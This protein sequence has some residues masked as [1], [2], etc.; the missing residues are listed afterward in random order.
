MRV[1]PD[2]LRRIAASRGANVDW[3]AYRELY[4]ARVALQG[5]ESHHRKATEVLHLFTRYVVDRPEPNSKLVRSLE[6]IDNSVYTRYLARRKKDPGKAKGTL[7]SVA[8]LNGDIRYLNAAFAIALRPTN[9]FPDRLGVADP[10]WDAPHMRLLKEP[11]TRPRSLTESHLGRLFSACQQAARPSIPGVTPEVWWQTLFLVAYTTG[12]RC[13]ALL[14]MPRPSEDDL[15]SETIRLPAEFD[16]SQEER[17]FHCHPQVAEMVRQI[18]SSP[19][20]RLFAWPHCRRYFYTVLYQFQTAAG[21]PDIEQVSPH[22]IRRTKATM[23]IRMGHSLP[24]VQRELGHATPS[25]T[26]RF[27]VGEVTDAQRAA[28]KALPMPRFQSGPERQLNLFN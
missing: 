26:A 3:T 20:G 6:D 15:D 8:T 9:E 13:R 11:K 17:A 23:L 2:P 14:A 12:L 28:V 16:K 22:D 25:T 1:S 24:V 5:S 19:C 27:Y 7:L 18:P 21:I 10:G 4:L